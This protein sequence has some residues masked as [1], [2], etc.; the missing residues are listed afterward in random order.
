MSHVTPP[1]SGGH[2]VP[3]FVP[4][5]QRYAGGGHWTPA[6]QR[7]AFYRCNPPLESTVKQAGKVAFPPHTGE[8]VYMVPFMKTDGEVLLPARLARWVPTV[9]AMLDGIETSARMYLMID[10]STVQA[11]ATHRRPGPHIDGNWN[12]R[13]GGEVA[14]EEF[15]DSELV[16]LAADVAACVGYV[17]K[18]PRVD[19][20]PGG[21]CS[22]MD[23]SKLERVALK[24]GYAYVMTVATIHESVPV[25]RDCDRTLVRINVPKG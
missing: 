25:K 23:L 9:T 8:R 11:G 19:F 2:R 1:R 13:G 21:D 4:E 10:Q 3:A 20:G 6:E 15:D 12:P 5:N 7:A 17:G 22:K 14:P 18:Y 16:V 24:A